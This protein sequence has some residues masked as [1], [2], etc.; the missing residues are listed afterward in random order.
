MSDNSKNHHFVP[1]SI[2]K[3]FSIKGKRKQIYVYDKKLNK[4]FP[5]G[6]SGAGSENYFNT[7][8]S[9]EGNFNFEPLFDVFDSKLAR[10]SQK[11]IQERSFDLF[12]ENDFN[13]LILIIAIQ[14]CRV[15][16]RR[17]N[18]QTF[19]DDVTS[20]AREL[21]GKDFEIKPPLDDEQIK[22]ITFQ[23]IQNIEPLLET[24]SKKDIYLA[25]GRSIPLWT[26]DN[27]VVMHNIYTTG[28][29]G[30][31]QR[32]IEIYYP[33]S[34]TLAIGFTCPS[35]KYELEKD[36]KT[37]NV[38]QKKILEVL[39]SK[40][41]MECSNEQVKSLNYLQVV[42]SS[43]FLYSSDNEFSRA[44]EFLNKNPDLMEV[45]SVFGLVEEFPTYHQL[46]KGEIIVACGKKTQCMINVYDVSD[47][48]LKFKTSK[49]DVLLKNTDNG[50]Y[51]E[52]IEYYK[53]KELSIAMR[54]LR[55]KEINWSDNEITLQ[56]I[57]FY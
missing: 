11:L 51:I 39:S 3:N 52:S 19:N 35:I 34:S 5:T 37:L 50:E 22:E 57:I 44:I 13:D 15:K 33:I 2:L 4:S 8:K 31:N 7:I 20:W 47:S 24:L 40:G 6:F 27:P 14:Y 25:V 53:N 23:H 36:Y 9:S 45:K 12:N 49:I 18:F 46:P 42:N 43:R 29:L 28:K 41:K 21:L 56:H 30:F 38:E 16:M 48:L 17:T 26:S 54:S 1:R 55:I 32:G 10:I